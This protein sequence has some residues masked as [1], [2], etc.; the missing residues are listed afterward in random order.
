MKIL[1]S[2]ICWNMKKH[3]MQQL[4]VLH[5]FILYIYLKSFTC[6]RAINKELRKKKNK[7]LCVCFYTEKYFRVL[8]MCSQWVCPSLGWLGLCL[9]NQAGLWRS[10]VLRYNIWYLI[11]KVK[12][13][14]CFY[15]LHCIW[16]LSGMQLIRNNIW[17]KLIWKFHFTVWRKS[18]L[19]S[20]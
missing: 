11:V 16:S 9:V 4:I 14:P 15:Q 7:S 1:L 19:R 10:N 6:L 12:H 5:W 2:W 20:H 17:L 13:I 8:R 3:W 18:L